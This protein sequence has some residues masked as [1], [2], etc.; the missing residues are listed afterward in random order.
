[1]RAG[2]ALRRAVMDRL[3]AQVPDL[4]ERV[5]DKAT[6]TDAYP[7]VTLGPSYWTDA[8]VECVEGRTITLQ[9]DVWCSGGAA[10]GKGNAEDVV[11]D[12]ATALNGWMDQGALTA[13]PARVTMVRVMDD[14]S[15]C[16]HGVVQVE[17]MAEAASI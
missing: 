5:Y 9:V 6:E 14:P 8:S 17:V 2:R 13:H 3:I 7:Y 12:V 1:M 10:A 11:D 15:G 4:G 16:V